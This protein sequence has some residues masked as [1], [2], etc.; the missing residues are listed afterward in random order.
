MSYL[1]GERGELQ[2]PTTQ[3]EKLPVSLAVGSVTVLCEARA[4]GHLSTSKVYALRVDELTQSCRASTDSESTGA[5]GNSRFIIRVHY[6]TSSVLFTSC[7]LFVPFLPV[8]H[9]MLFFFCPPIP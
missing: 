5:R 3:V 4:S 8:L 6:I 1:Q 2:T 9:D 7:H